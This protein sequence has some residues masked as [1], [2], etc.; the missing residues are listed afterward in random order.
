MQLNAELAMGPVQR[1][2]YSE[3]P[4]AYGHPSTPSP[5]Y[6]P[7]LNYGYPSTPSP[8]YNPPME[9]FPQRSPSSVSDESNIS[10]ASLQNM[11][12]LVPNTHYFTEYPANYAH[13]YQ[14]YSKYN[15]HTQATDLTEKSPKH[16]TD[17]DSYSY[18]H[19]REYN[20]NAVET[21]PDPR[22]LNFPT[23]QETVQPQFAQKQNTH[24]VDIKQEYMP[25]PYTY[26]SDPYGYYL[27][28][29]NSQYISE[30]MPF[31]NRSVPVSPSVSAYPELF[32]NG[33]SVVQKRKRRTMKRVPVV[34]TCPYK[35]CIK[36]YNKA[37]HMKAHLRSHTGEKPYVCTW[38]GCGW[39]FSRSDELGRHSRKHTGVRPYACKLCERA[40]ARSD[41]LALHIK[42]HM[43]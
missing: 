22:T 34:H 3:L 38:Q 26:N 40:F 17:L 18:E 29:Y 7:P 32:T 21:K 43:E 6:S 10:S 37:S 1:S 9:V 28:S 23:Y 24:F 41:H 31:H 5:T 20:N 36:T 14:D 25:L 27:Q 39:K 16:V 12:P 11:P 42:K 2:D 33:T 19:Y 30:T 13:Q 8:T 4:S 35:G 15:A